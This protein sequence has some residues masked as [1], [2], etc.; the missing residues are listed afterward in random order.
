MFEKKIVVAAIAAAIATPGAAV[1]QTAG[2]LDRI[3]AQLRGLKEDYEARIRALED[4]LMAAETSATQAAA[5]AAKAKS[6]ATTAATAAAGAA[7]T[8]AEA[9]TTAQRAESAAQNAGQQKSQNAFNP[10]ISLILNG[11]WGR[12]GNDPTN[13]ISGF[14]SSGLGE[15]TPRGASLGESELYL[16]ANIDPNF[17]G[18]LL[19]AFTPENTVEIEEAFIETLALGRGITAKGGRFFSGIGYGNSRHPHAWDFVDASLVQRA[20]LGRNY[21]DDGLQLRWVAPLPVFVE[22]GGEIGRGREFAGSPTEFERNRNGKEAHALYAKVG[23]DV[24]VEH[25]YQVGV[26]HL[27]MRTPA[28]TGVTVL[29]FDDT[30][31]L[32]NVFDGRQRVTGADFV[33][34]WAPDGN[35]AY[36]NFKFVAE[37]FQRRLDGDMTFDTTN[38]GAGTLTDAARI[39]QSGWYAQAAYQFMPYWRVGARYDRL[40]HGTANLNANAANLALP[41]FDPTRTS[42]MVDY[43]PSEFSRMRV[44]YNR[45]RLLQDAAGATVDDN[46]LFFQY[47]MSL[48]AHGAHRF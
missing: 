28:G 3:R 48:G 4:K 17:R 39:R 6:E 47:I 40:S 8:A 10:A 25:S 33:W 42:L 2:E 21:G 12:Y 29:D 7:S 31:G 30:T 46:V 26:S 20:F 15:A 27:R 24:G 5:D 18:S 36:R 32:V 23:G 19:A 41:A 45:D 22:L 13:Q 1:A 11:T 43:S 14:A 38:A 37:W 35:P 16:T 34:K 44:Q 9:T